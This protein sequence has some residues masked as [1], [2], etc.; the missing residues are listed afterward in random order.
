[1]GKRNSGL[2][3]RVEEIAKVLDKKKL[4]STARSRSMD[5]ATGE[6][7]KAMLA[8]MEMEMADA[9]E[10]DLSALAKKERQRLERFH[11]EVGDVVEVDKGRKGVLHFCGEVHFAEGLL[12]GVE[13]LDKSMGK[14]NG[15]VGETTYFECPEKKGVFFTSDKIR[16]KAVF[17]TISMW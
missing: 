12:F 1:M 8:E 17:E 4:K 9:A 13:F 10:I 2:F 6:R 16:K 7:L 3:V 14:Y 11:L 15:T 5:K